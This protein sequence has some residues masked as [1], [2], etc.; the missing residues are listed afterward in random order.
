MRREA[1]DQGSASSASSRYGVARGQ[2]PVVN[3]A[4]SV[5][6]LAKSE[7][8]I[9]HRGPAGWL[10]PRARCAETAA[11]ATVAAVALRGAETAGATPRATVGVRPHAREAGTAEA[12][13]DAALV[14]TT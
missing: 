6:V 11:G 4:I 2:C 13:A 7:V 9:I 5:W 8:L 1:A 3:R 14:P 12:G 10:D